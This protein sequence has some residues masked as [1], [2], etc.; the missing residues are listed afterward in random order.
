MM[1]QMRNGDYIPGRAGG[2]VRL[3]GA[4]A[5]LMR[6]LFRLQCRRGALPMLPALGSRLWQLRRALPSARRTLAMAYCA[7]ALRELPVTVTG[8]ELTEQPEGRLDLTVLLRWE[9]QMLRA[10][11]KI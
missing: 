6:V 4:E 3:E 1:L 2:Y 8:V 11:V 7:E 9:G 10:E 5:L